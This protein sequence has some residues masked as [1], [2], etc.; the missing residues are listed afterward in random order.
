MD[1]ANVELASKEMVKHAVIKLVSF[2]EICSKTL[3]Y[4]QPVHLFFINKP[5]RQK[6]IVHKISYNW[7]FPLFTC[8]IGLKTTAVM[9]WNYFTIFN[10][11]ESFHF[12]IPKS[13]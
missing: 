3:Q 12:T 1:I 9:L 5:F 13:A 2:F 7:P 11:A 4:P 10:D 8:C 6:D